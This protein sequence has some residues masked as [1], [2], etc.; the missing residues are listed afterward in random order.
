MSENEKKPIGLK[1]EWIHEETANA[2]RLLEIT[3]AIGRYAE[4]NLP[5]PQE[6]LVELMERRSRSN[7]RSKSEPA[8]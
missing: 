2:M 4:A 3:M 6:W 5:V 1:P 8:L 7:E